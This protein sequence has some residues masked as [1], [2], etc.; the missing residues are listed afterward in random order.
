MHLVDGEVEVLVNLVDDPAL[1]L[2]M[3]PLKS[4]GNCS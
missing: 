1:Q 3:K 4:K 2:P